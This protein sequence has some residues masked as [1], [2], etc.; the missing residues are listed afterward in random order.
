MPKL[1][2]I[3]T[4]KLKALDGNIKSIIK[5]QLWVQ[6]SVPFIVG[7]TIFLPLIIGSL[8]NGHLDVA[9][10]SVSD[11]TKNIGLTIF[12]S[13]ACY[14]FSIPISIFTALCLILLNKFNRLN[15]VNIAIGYFCL[16]AFFIAFLIIDG[17]R[18]H[19]DSVSFLIFLMIVA[20]TTMAYL[21]TFFYLKK[22][23]VL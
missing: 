22:G 2:G 18:L 16:I 7:V 10:D 4:N 15:T 6:A 13:L 23:S 9:F 5:S 12:I 11:I 21:I 14:M 17:L 19:S 20:P 8:I 1:A 3:S